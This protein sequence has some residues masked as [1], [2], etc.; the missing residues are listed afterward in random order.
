[1]CLRMTRM[2]RMFIIVIVS[3]RFSRINRS[4]ISRVRRSMVSVV[5]V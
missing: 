4:C 5:V 1:M 3:D 2:I